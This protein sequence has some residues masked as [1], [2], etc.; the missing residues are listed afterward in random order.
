[1]IDEWVLSLGLYADIIGKRFNKQHKD[2]ARKLKNLECSSDFIER[3]FT[4]NEYRDG[5]GR[6]LPMFEM[7][8]DGCIFLWDSLARG[9]RR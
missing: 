7:T 4:L 2:V 9:L 8:K 1:M 6:K 3:N 5:I